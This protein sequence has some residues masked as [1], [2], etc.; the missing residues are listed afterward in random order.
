MAHDICLLVVSL[1]MSEVPLHD[2]CLLSGMSYY[3]A[4]EHSASDG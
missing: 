3:H 2:C 1:S 4:G